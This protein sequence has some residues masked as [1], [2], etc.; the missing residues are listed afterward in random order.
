MPQEGTAPVLTEAELFAGTNFTVV[1]LEWDVQALPGGPTIN[2]ND[3]VLNAYDSLL[4]LD[5]KV[6]R[7]DDDSVFERRTDFPGC[8][9][10]C[11]GGWPLNRAGEAI[12][13]IG[14]L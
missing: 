8:S 6:Q 2:L 13:G 11:R 4:E 12:K 5:P 10:F 14:Y 7:C 1:D 9:Y 3:S